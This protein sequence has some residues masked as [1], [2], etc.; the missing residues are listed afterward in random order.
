MMPSGLR[1]LA[2]RVR[3]WARPLGYPV[4]CGTIGCALALLYFWPLPLQLTSKIIGDHPDR[5]FSLWGIDWALR[6]WF[7]LRGELFSADILAPHRDAL[8]FSDSFI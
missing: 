4:L 7:G 6:Q 5:Y 2:R 1:E 3:F 8:L